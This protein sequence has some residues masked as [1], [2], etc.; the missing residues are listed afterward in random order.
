MRRKAFSVAPVVIGVM[1]P[2]HLLAHT[3]VL[4]EIRIQSSARDGAAESLLVQG[5]R[6]GPDHNPIDAVFANVFFNHGL[7]G[8]GAQRHV[9]A[10]DD[11]V[12]QFLQRCGHLIDVDHIA[13]VAAAATGVH[14]DANILITGFNRHWLIGLV[15]LVIQAWTN[16]FSAGTGR[17][18]VTR[19]FLQ[20]SGGFRS[21]CARRHDAID[22]VHRP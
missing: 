21:G 14:P 7:P 6:A 4:I 15:H 16:S 5:G 1:H 3:H 18:T 17:L 11:D 8:I 20:I 10:R 22:D 9:G 19:L 2:A 12:G 13:D